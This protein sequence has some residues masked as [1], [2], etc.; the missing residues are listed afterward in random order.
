MYLDPLDT[1]EGLQQLLNH[2][3]P[4]VGEPAHGLPYEDQ[5]VHGGQFV[6]VTEELH[7]ERDHGVGNIWELYTGRVQGSY[8]EIISNY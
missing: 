8:L 7:E 4:E 5:D 2:D 1:G 6:G 3:G